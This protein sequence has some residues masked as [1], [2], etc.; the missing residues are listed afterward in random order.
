MELILA[1]S[2]VTIAQKE[3]QKMCQIKRLFMAPSIY[4][5]LRCLRNRRK[6][7]LTMLLPWA[8]LLPAVSA[9]A[10][11]MRAEIPAYMQLPFIEEDAE[12]SSGLRTTW[13]CVSFGRYPSAEV[14]DSEWDS[15]DGYALRDGDVI[16]DDDLYA[17]LAQADWAE[18]RS[19][20]HTSELQSRI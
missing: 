8:F 19:E 9:Y 13:S 17:M 18:D 14:V 4:R 11:D 16:R 7:L 1:L 3:D 6:P 15:V 20:E 5:L 10:E 12:T 2:D